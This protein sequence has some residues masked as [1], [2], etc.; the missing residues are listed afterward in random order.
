MEPVTTAAKFLRS[1]LKASWAL[2]DYPV[3]VTER[4]ART[5]GRRQAFTWTAQIV[6]WWH[7]RGDGFT[8]EEAML[9]L[10][11]RFAA[12]KAA[13]P[14]PR[15]GRGA[16]L[17]VELASSRVV[18]E[19]QEIVDDL[20]RRVV[21]VDPHE[22]LITDE[23]SLWD[24]HDQESNEPYLQRIRELYDID[25]SDMDPPTLANLSR[26]IREHKGA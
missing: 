9:R 10:Q 8:R 11:E 20:L 4:P 6:N 17:Q 1:F 19:N 22:C 26:R 5:S 7:M 23:S 13:K 3:R 15:P 12:Y 2:E 14:L 18:E 16:P 25:A 24:F 21:G